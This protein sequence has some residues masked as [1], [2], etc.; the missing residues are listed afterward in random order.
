VIQGGV[1]AVW[2][3]SNPKHKCPRF[4][5]VVVY[6]SSRNRSEAIAAS[7]EPLPKDIRGTL[8]L[9]PK[10]SLYSDDIKKAHDTEFSVALE[11]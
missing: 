11:R 10:C 6:G 9:G 4:G 8:I 7:E 3:I 1:D 2:L 5:F